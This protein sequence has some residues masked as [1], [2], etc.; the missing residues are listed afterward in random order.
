MLNIEVFQKQGYCWFSISLT[1]PEPSTG[2]TINRQPSKT[3]YFHRR[4]SIDQANISCQMSQ[5]S[6]I[7]N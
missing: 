4:P 6:L 3:Q 1:I 7:K 5:I 2:Q